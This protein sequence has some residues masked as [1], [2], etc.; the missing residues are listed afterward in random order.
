[1]VLPERGTIGIIGCRAKLTKYANGATLQINAMLCE[2][3]NMLYLSQ[4]EYV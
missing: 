1:M 3:A 2:V 4:A